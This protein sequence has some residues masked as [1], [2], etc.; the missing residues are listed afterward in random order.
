[1]PVTHKDQA[2]VDMPLY[3]LVKASQ[4]DKLFGLEALYQEVLE[5]NKDQDEWESGRNLA[6]MVEYLREVDGFTGFALFRYEV[7][8]GNGASDLAEDEIAALTEMLPAPDAAA[9][10]A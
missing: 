4:A 7:L 3:V 6:D 1:M 9:A 8:Y 2:G 10:T 5:L